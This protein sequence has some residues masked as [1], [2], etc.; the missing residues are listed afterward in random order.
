MRQKGGG[1]GG[2]RRRREGWGAR[3]GHTSWLSS[4][5][6]L[7][8]LVASSS[9][10]RIRYLHFSSLILEVICDHNSSEV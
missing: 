8:G 6:D 9:S 10:S 3:G 2:Q 7:N 5:E 1:E 4:K